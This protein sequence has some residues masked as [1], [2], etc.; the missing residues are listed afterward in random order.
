MTTARKLGVIAVSVMALTLAA[1]T[2]STS[3]PPS[4]RP[5]TTPTTVRLPSTSTTVTSLPLTVQRRHCSDGDVVDAASHMRFAPLRVLCI[6]TV[7]SSNGA[8]SGGDLYIVT[9]PSATNAAA[10]RLVKISLSSYHVLRR[11]S[12]LRDGVAAPVVAFGAVWVVESLP[13]SSSQRLLEFS[14]ADLHLLKQIPLGESGYDLVAFG[15]WFWSIAIGGALERLDPSTG[16]STVVR[17]GSLPP[18]ATFSGI[19][20]FGSSMLLS[21]IGPQA[22]DSETVVYRPGFGVTRQVAAPDASAEASDEVFAATRD[23]VWVYPPGLND[24]SVATLSARSLQRL[25]AGF[26][27]GG[28]NGTWR[29]IFS[30]GDLW[31]QLGGAPLVCVSGVS[32][33]ASAAL[34]LPGSV[35][36]DNLAASRA[37]AFVASGNGDMVIGAWLGTAHGAVASGLAFYRLDPRCEQSRA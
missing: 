29:S 12:V 8:V 10:F 21:T 28:P 33:V 1:C 22:A 27:A 6:G 11:S 17:L 4:T 18:H 14:E 9:T 37:P 15:S 2:S 24:H 35:E 32:G 23:V 5:S 13:D 20:A 16:V 36:V 31:F 3:S 7:S 25:R 26:Q 34:R 19:A 30:G